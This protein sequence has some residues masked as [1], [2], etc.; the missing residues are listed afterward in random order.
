MHNNSYFKLRD[1]ASEILKNLSAVADEDYLYSI[2]ILRK[3][4]NGTWM[5]KF[6]R[7]GKNPHLRYFWIHPYNK[8]IYWSRR[9]PNEK[10]RHQIKTKSGKN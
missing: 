5:Y 6:N 7:Y 3:T 4:M 1:N 10:Y 8:L 9:E 2:N